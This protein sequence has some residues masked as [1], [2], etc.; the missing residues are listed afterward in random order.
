MPIST[1][2]AKPASVVFSVC[3]VCGHSSGIFSHNTT[4]IWLGRGKIRSEMPPARQMSSHITKND[5]RAS[6]D[7]RR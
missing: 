6:A 5:S 2:S 3:T 7:N 1:P 4:A